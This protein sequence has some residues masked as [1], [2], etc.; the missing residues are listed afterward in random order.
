[1][2][3]GADCPCAHTPLRDELVRIGSMS[4]RALNMTWAYPWMATSPASADSGLPNLQVVL[5]K[6]SKHAM[7][8]WMSTKGCGTSRAPIDSNDVH[9]HASTD[10]CP[11]RSLVRR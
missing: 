1:M 7:H 6:A 11:N 4:G 9:P 5:V 2:R 3:Q 8:S 10:P